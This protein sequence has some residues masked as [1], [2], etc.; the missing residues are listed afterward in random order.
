LGWVGLGWIRAVTVAKLANSSRN[1]F[2]PP[3]PQG[4]PTWYPATHC[5]V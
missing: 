1:H 2:R 3:N 4:S 5:G